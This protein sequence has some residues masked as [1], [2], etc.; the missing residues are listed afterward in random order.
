[1]RQ[2]IENKNY[3]GERALYFTQDAVIR[4]CTF[5]GPADG[6]SA[7]KESC[8]V[9]LENCVFSLRYPLWHV[10]NFSLASCAVDEPARA[11]L[12]YAEDGTISGCAIR[13]VK[14]V[15]ECSR[16]RISDTKIASPEFGWKCRG[17]TA[18]NSVMESEYLFLDSRAVRMRNVRTRGKYS[19]Q[20]TEDAEIADCELDTKD[21]FW[22][23][24]NVTV[25][26]SVVRGEYLAWYSDGL[27]LI[28]CKL[29][30]TQPFCYCRNLR[31]VNCTMEGCDLAFEY[32][33]VDAD[34]AGRIDS[35]K[36]P[37]SGTI[38][39]GGVGKIIRERPVMECRGAVVV[40]KEARTAV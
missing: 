11:A 12:W 28:D 36:N 8:G 37:R 6:E 23:S 34:V 10:R 16:I 40:R 13:G 21:A 3:D 22:H 15:R 20:Y 26:N 25:R 19:F 35:V 18:E 17:V 1:M 2:I 4:N 9:E 14:A 5:A 39:C 7:L 27:T 29:S 24:R 31:L 38:L 30:G 32:S 33:D